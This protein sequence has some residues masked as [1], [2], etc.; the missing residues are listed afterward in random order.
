M[1][2]LAKT[3]LDGFSLSKSRGLGW[4]YEKACENRIK[5]C[6]ALALHVKQ[7]QPPDVY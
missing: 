7:R 3:K 4:D 2:P 1:H 5:Y 6:V